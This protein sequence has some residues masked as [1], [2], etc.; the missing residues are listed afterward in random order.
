MD[1]Y[2]WGTAAKWSR[3]TSFETVF[4][5][6]YNDYAARKPIMVSETASAEHGGNKAKWIAEAAAAVRSRFPDLVA[7]VWFNADKP[8]ETDWRV[9]SSSSALDAFTAWIHDPYFNVFGR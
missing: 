6:L 8:E 3:W 1:G 5:P 2:N 4:R 9:N 7:I